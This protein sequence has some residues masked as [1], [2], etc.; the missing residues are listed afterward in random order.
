MCCCFFF[1]Y[2]QTTNGPMTVDQNNMLVC[3][4][5]MKAAN[6]TI[7]NH[8]N[9]FH[10]MSDIEKKSVHNSVKKL[11][12]LLNNYC[13]QL[14]VIGYNSSRYDVC[15]VRKQLFAQNGLGNS[16]KHLLSRNT[17]LTCVF[18]LLLLNFWMHL[19]I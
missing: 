7:A 18:L 16:K 11:L 12:S 3:N 2:L 15:L 14:P 6:V 8:S 4:D 10:V 13:T 5:S 19:T 9:T 1:F 17:V